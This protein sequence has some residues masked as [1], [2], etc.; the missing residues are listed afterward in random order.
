MCNDIS[1]T[2]VT[3]PLLPQQR[4]HIHTAVSN[5]SW[6]IPELQELLD[7]TLP[8]DIIHT[9]DHPSQESLDESSDI[10]DTYHLS[11]PSETDDID[12]TSTPIHDNHHIPLDMNETVIPTNSQEY[13]FLHIDIPTYYHYIYHIHIS[14]KCFNITFIPLKIQLIINN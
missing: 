4:T 1:N 3:L 6:D 9:T 12:D 14:E 2:D 5:L 7:F 10:H 8:E 11:N 13:I